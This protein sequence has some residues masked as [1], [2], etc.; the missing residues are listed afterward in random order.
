[1]IYID[2]QPNPS[3]SYPNAKN[4]PFHG[5]IPLTDEQAET[6][7]EYNGFVTVTQD[8]ESVTVS[9]NT[10]AWDS[11]KASLPEPEEPAPTPEERIA[12]LEAENVTIKEQ[13][14]QADDTAIELYEANLAQEEIN[15][16]QDDAL[17][18][19]YELIGG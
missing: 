4:Q 5:C 17:I 19:I 10:E 3:G 13:L 8:G 2:K 11:W 9:P 16:A 12:A 6:F 14:Q 1:M 7:F 15:A 18:E